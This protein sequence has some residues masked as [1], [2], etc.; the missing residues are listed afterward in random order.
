MADPTAPP[1]SRRLASL[2]PALRARPRLVGAILFGIGVD[3]A[4]QL[5]DLP[6]AT[7]TLVAWNAGSLLYLLLAWHLMLEHDVRLIQSRA[8]TQDEGRL[9]ILALVV[10]AAAAVLVAVGTQLVQVKS[11]EGSER[12][13]HLV[14]AGLTVVTSWLFTQVLFALHYAHDFYMARHRGQADPLAFPG[15]RDPGYGDFFYF[16]CVIGTSGQT[17]DVSFTGRAMR[18]VGTLHCV[19]AFFFNATLLALSINV[20]AGLL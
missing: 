15:T 6:A 12:D 16:A 14:L 3:A 11:L 5:A 2:W 4:L 19:L 13:W 7:R 9:T 1:D 20:A 10:G 17:A 18:P 8:V